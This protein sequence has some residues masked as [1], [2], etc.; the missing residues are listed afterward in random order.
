VEHLLALEGI[1]VSLITMQKVLNEHEFGTRFER[2][3]A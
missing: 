2:Q 3:Q 1:H